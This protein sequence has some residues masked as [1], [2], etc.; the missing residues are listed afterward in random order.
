M[1]PT[2]IHFIRTDIWRIRRQNMPPVRSFLIKVMRIVLLALRGFDEDECYLRASAITFYSLLSIVPVLAM[3]FGIAKGFGFEAMLREQI[4]AQLSGQ[5]EVADRVIRFAHS[6]LEEARG[7]VIAGA[8]VVL[9]FWAVIKMLGN[10][11]KS[12]N[13]IW[14]VKR[15]RSTVRK[16]S[17]YLSIALICPILLIMSSSITVFIAGKAE[18]MGPVASVFLRFLPYFFTWTLFAFIYVFMPNTRVDSR[19]GILAGIVAGTLF[20][21]LYVIYVKFQIGAVR[22]S[23]IYGSFA[24]LPLFLVWLQLSWLIVLFGAEVSFA[25]QNVET[26]EFEPDCLQASYSFKKRLSLLVTHLIVKNFCKGEKP[27][28]AA[29]I[30]HALEMPIRLA[31]EILYELVEAGVLS[32][33]AEENTDKVCYQPGRSIESMT[34]KFIIDRLEHR[35]SNEIPVVQSE[36]LGKLTAS[37]AEFGNLIERSPANILLKDI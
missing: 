6:L 24:A 12:F 20:Q 10:I 29:E 30:S 15:S 32:E 34:L 26:Y 3:A 37:L 36:P 27:W 33:T 18:T 25:D 9:L 4:L 31:R 22:Y 2:I 5:E 7:G 16:F 1:I 17:D 14:G 8:G 23:A 21:I 19:S 35:G 11:E 28:T 13:D